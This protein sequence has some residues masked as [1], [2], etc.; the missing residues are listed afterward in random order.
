MPK[1]EKVYLLLYLEEMVLKVGLVR[2]YL[3]L[4]IKKYMGVKNE[5]S[6]I[7]MYMCSCD[8]FTSPSTS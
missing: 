7:S 1:I 5:K 3:I 2:M 4:L 8:Y 6:K